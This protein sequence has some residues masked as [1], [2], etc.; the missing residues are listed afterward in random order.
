MRHWPRVTIV[1][2][3]KWLEEGAYPHLRKV[4]LEIRYGRVFAPPVSLMN[5]IQY[6]VQLD[7]T[8]SL[9]SSSYEWEI[10]P[11]CTRFAILVHQRVKDILASRVLGCWQMCC[12]GWLE[13]A[14]A[15]VPLSLRRTRVPRYDD[16]VAYLPAMIWSTDQYMK[17]VQRCLYLLHCSMAET[18]R[19]VRST[20]QVQHEKSARQ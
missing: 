7:E 11:S 9:R 16:H 4:T 3:L 13:E 14:L 12:H 6:K 15:F 5:R 2:S 19:I 8:E 10:R 20:V 17:V 18:V 1:L